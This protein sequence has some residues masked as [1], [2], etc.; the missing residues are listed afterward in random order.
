MDGPLMLRV[1]CPDSGRRVIVQS[2]ERYSSLT[3]L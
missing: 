1:A 3:F 2:L